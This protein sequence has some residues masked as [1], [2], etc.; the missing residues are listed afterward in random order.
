[1]DTQHIDLAGV[2]NPPVLGARTKDMLG[3]F[4][5]ERRGNGGFSPSPS[6]VRPKSPRTVSRMLE[7]SPYFLALLSLSATILVSNQ[8]DAVKVNRP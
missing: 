5:D 8:I 3:I 4:E 2:E 6:G 7:S 1:M